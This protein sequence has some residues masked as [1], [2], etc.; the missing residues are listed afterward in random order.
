MNDFGIKI[1]KNKNTYVAKFWFLDSNR[2]VHEETKRF[3]IKSFA[4]RWSKKKIYDKIASQYI[5]ENL[6]D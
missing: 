6:N 2:I 5:K 1:S 3:F 4:I